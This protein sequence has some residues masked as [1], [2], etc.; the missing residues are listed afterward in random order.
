M[1]HPV[2]AAR[3]VPPR[4]GA[5]YQIRHSLSL[6]EVE[7]TV[8][9]G[10]LTELAGARLARPVREHCLQQQVQH[11]WATVAV[12]FEHVLAGEGVR[13]REVERQAFVQR[14]AIGAAEAGKADVARGGRTA[15]QGACNLRHAR[16]G[17]AHD[18]DTTDSRRCG[19]GCDGV[20][21]GRRVHSSTLTPP[22][23]G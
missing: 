22:G 4:R 19:N 10:A 17:D 20:A 21:G 18:A 12:Q 14:A 6:D 9:E 2:N 11:H 15:K 8:Q 23:R 3:R 1:R 7:L 5:F 16:P 13:G